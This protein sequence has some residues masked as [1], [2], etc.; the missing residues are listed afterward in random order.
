MNFQN[1]L[2]EEMVKTFLSSL[3]KEQLPWKAC[4]QT[5]LPENT[6]T[7]KR[8]HGI[9]SLMLSYAAAQAGYGDHRWCTFKQAAEKGWH[10]LKGAKA[11]PVEYWAYYDRDKKK[12]LSWSD[13]RKIIRDNPDYASDNLVLR[14]RLYSVFNAAQIEG[15][16]ELPYTK[17]ISAESIRSQRDTLFHNMNLKLREGVSQP[18]YA[19]EIDTVCLPYEKDFYDS[20]G[21]ACTFL[22]ECGHAT[23]HETRLNRDLTAA[24]GT[25]GYAKEELRAEI[26]SAFAAQAMGLQL[27]D[28][29][30][31]AHMNLHTAY[32]QSWAKDIKNA[33][34][35]LFRAI[36]DAER[37]S[38]YLIEKGEFQRL[39]DREQ[40]PE[41]SYVGR[42]DY[43]SPSGKVEESLRFRSQEELI[44]TVKHETDI[45]APFILV[46]YTNSDNKTIPTD[47]LHD[48]SA[49]P[50]EIRTESISSMKAN[51]IPTGRSQPVCAKQVP[52]KTP[53][54]QRSRRHRELER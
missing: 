17:N 18:Y 16:P 47:F 44:H 3:E 15:V 48:L 52:S 50:R 31:Q 33:P 11:T 4:W 22:H 2:R 40:A 9:N 54:T 29:Q 13:A 24:F 34:E 37:I 49:M 43:L 53:K 41:P 25:S 32:I 26:A 36:K 21:Y 46:L 51:D 6:V 39:E 27:S 10:I 7:G 8:Y 5:A 12:L 42:I 20:Y 38:D 35:E 23:G 45:G 1:K 19:P 30:L 28:Q 14:S